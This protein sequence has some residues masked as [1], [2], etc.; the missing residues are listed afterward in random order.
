MKP[1]WIA[2]TLA[3]T[4]L[5]PLTLIAQ[6]EGY[7]LI[8]MNGRI[9]DGSGNPWFYGDVAIRGDRIIKIGKVGPAR[10]RRRIDAT[11]MIVAP[12]FID[13]L[14]QSEVNLLIDPRAESKVFQG[15]TTEVTGEGGSAA[16]L[17]DYILKELDPFLKHFKVTADWRTLGEY[18]SRLERSHS[19]INLA[20]YV[21]A[22]QVRQYVLHDENRAPTADELE[23][24]RKLVAQA[25]EDGAV[26]ISTSLVYAPAFYAKTE[27]LIEL[28]KV[29]SRYGGVYATHMRNESNSIMS[30]LDEAIRIGT[31]ANIPVE[32]FHLKM[33][34]KPNWGR[35]RDV[36]AKIEAARSRGLDITADQYPYVAGATSL[37]AAVPPWAHE[38]GTAKFVERLKDPALREKL[39]RE[40][41]APSDNW[42]NFYLG[43]GGGEGILV[44][45]VLNRDL[46]K[47][48]GKRI[49][50][51]ARMMNKSDDIEAL[52]DL[53]IADNAQTGMI[54]F[55][56]SEDDVKL[57]LKQPW[58]S[59]GVDHGAVALAGPLAEGKAH[60]RG[61]GAFP[62][63]LGRYVR[64]ERVLTLEEAIRKMTS[65]AA[66]RVHL[67][68]RGLLK[69]GFFADI[70]V[71]DPQQIRDVATFE[72]PN[73]LSFGMRYVLVNGVPVVFAGNQTNALPGRPLR[74][75]GYKGEIKR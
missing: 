46:A 48:E 24:M 38:G 68:G 25:M 44:T 49:N 40:M 61:Y 26:G 21:G 74:G 56:M 28:A 16:P 33:A 12:G 22:T 51:I 54:V 57:A 29:A 9:V 73:R 53:L 41:R 70:V 27:E 50:E 31:E 15:I 19:A 67:E 6:V 23:Q 13:M 30:A 62:R 69:P 8:I 17:N 72:D 5:A 11:G 64:D 58:V 45:S 18:F 75:P 60:P 65:L 1:L 14:G 63:I 10:A 20:T 42:E 66:N 35:M 59:V 71:F 55:L 36:I 34:G 52:F 7:D 43:A 37:G 2:L 3:A 47:Y 39:K 4:L 32:I